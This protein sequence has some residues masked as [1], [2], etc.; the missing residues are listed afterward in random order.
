[1]TEKELENKAKSV[2]DGIKYRC[3]VGRKNYEDCEICEEWEIFENFK[4]WYMEHYYEVYGCDMEVDKDILIPGN[5]IYSPETCMIV[6]Q[7]INE[8]FRTFSN[9]YNLPSG[10]V[11]LKKDVKN[12]RYRVTYSGN[13]LGYFK[14]IK[15]ACIAHE[16]A[17][18]GAINE[19]AKTYKKDL[20]QYVYEALINWQPEFVF[21]DYTNFENGDGKFEI[22][23]DDLGLTILHMAKQIGTL[24][25]V[26][27]IDILDIGKAIE[28]ESTKFLYKVDN[29]IFN[30]NELKRI[31]EYL[32][33]D[34]TAE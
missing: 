9:K 16:Y 17:K 33:G 4:K 25:R 2:W 20:P 7:R 8:L 21:D 6:P 5:R 14:T 13:F 28:C 22:H 12:G 1:M 23:T 24:A 32:G 11:L 29:G 18:K 34:F 26:M 19:V 27:N 30:I 31:A 3:K 15:D 10:I